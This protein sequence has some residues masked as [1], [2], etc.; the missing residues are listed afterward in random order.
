MSLLSCATASFSHGDVSMISEAVDTKQPCH[1]RLILVHLNA[2][3]P[4]RHSI[5]T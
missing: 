1:T 5:S 2:R 4:A 3:R